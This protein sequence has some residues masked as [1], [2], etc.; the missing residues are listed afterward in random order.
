MKTSAGIFNE[1]IGRGFDCGTDGGE[2][3]AQAIFSELQRQA[4]FYSAVPD[5]V[6]SPQ[7]F[8]IIHLAWVMNLIKLLAL[9]Q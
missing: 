2:F 1:D 5:P 9:S 6:E 4:R 8:M 3:E 7:L